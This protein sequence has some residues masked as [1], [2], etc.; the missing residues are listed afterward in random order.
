MTLRSVAFG[1]VF[2][3]LVAAVPALAWVG[4]ERLLDSKGGEVVVG[5]TDP[6]EPG[7]RALVVPTETGLVLQRDDE[8]TITATTLLALGAGEAGGTV[9][10]IPMNT[11]VREQ[12]FLFDRLSVV[13]ANSSDELY[14]REVAD[15]LN[16][17]I[18]MDNVVTID[19]E[20]LASLTAPV[21]PLAIDNPDPVLTDDGETIPAGPVELS[22]DQV[23]PYLRASA[24]GEDELARLARNEL[25]WSAW[26]AAVGEAGI[27]T[28]VG[29][30]FTDIGP[31]IRTLA[32]GEAMVQTLNVTLPPESDQPDP[33]YVPAEGFDDQILDAVPYPTSPSPGRRWE[34]VLLNGSSP[35][36]EI[37]RE[38]MRQ[39]IGQGAALTTLGNAAAFGEEGTVVEYSGSEWRDAAERAA[40]VLGEGVEVERMSPVRAEQ[41]GADVVITLGSTTLDRFEEGG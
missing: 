34:L 11:K 30:G 6:D 41:A 3:L 14:V 29:Q 38:L 25:V 37:P 20:S 8:G 39:L 5:G 40:F 13:A 15:L 21:A 31:F 10:Q 32:S 24:G 18:P 27:E 28:G 7:Y 2:A 12:K 23:G 9:L 16:V 35:D 19:D 4:K 33:P 26:L 17:G 22:A 36:D 1:T